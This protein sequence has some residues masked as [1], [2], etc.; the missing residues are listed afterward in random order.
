MNSLAGMI[1]SIVNIYTAQHGVWSITARITA[2]VIGSCLIIAGLLFALYNFWALRRVRKV[3]EAELGLD[4][5]HEG[6]GIVEK[7]KRKAHE[8][9]LQPGS[10]V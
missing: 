4:A 8:P 1:T 5:R 3:H 10:V 9:P 7:V 6:E 2:I